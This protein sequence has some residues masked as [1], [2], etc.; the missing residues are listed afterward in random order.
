M[1]RMSA[2]SGVLVL[3]FSLSGP[4]AAA[5]AIVGEWNLDA[6]ACE[7]ARIAYT[8]DGRHESWQREGEGWTTTASGQYRV[9]DGSLVVEYQGQSE[10]LEIVSLDGDTLELRNADPARMSDAGVDSVR[11]VRCPAR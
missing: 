4:L 10:T 3:L 9:E 5:D 7:Q 8:E 1:S 11:F 6:A 2:R